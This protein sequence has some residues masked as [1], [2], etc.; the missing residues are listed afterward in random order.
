MVFVSS[1]DITG[2]NPTLTPNIFMAATDGS[3]T[4]QVTSLTTGSV[5]NPAISGDGSTIYFTSSN[6]LT[7]GNPINDTQI[8]S[9]SPD[10][11]N[12]AQV[13]TGVAN[14][15]QIEIADTANKLV[16]VDT[17]DPFGTNAD[18]SQEIFAMNT[19]GTNFMQLTMSAGNSITPRISDNG[20]YV[21]FTSSGEFT[22]GSNTDG[23]LEVYVA[24]TDGAAL[25][26]SRT[27]RT[28]QDCAS[29]ARRP[30]SISRATVS[31]SRS[32][33]TATSRA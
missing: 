16:W 4:T 14:A 3:S 8:F 20:N 32:C 15:E 33:P 23:S 19:D 31:T 5:G 6:D 28:T 10:G 7:G 25:R 24:D 1:E 22:A 12:L 21:V 2:S 13:T 9:I 18:G 26:R 27:V 29:T 30:R 11:T 17:S